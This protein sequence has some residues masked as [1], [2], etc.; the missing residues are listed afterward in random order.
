MYYK[1]S[2]ST[3]ALKLYRLNGLTYLFSLIYR[4]VLLEAA[5]RL[6]LEEL[7]FYLD[8]TRLY[9]IR[10][11]PENSKKNLT[12]AGALYGKN[13]SSERFWDNLRRGDSQPASQP[14]RLCIVNNILL[15]SANVAYFLFSASA[16]C[17]FSHQT[18]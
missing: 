18:L 16:K 2:S 11:L 6:E 15:H 7:A 10:I 1:L 3:P 5:R 13:I 8:K 12:P 4:N 9:L 17:T 14:A